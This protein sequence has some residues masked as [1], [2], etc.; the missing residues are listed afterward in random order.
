MKRTPSFYQQEICPIVQEETGKRDFLMSFPDY[1]CNLISSVE[2]LENIADR[3]YQPLI[4]LPCQI[5]S[6]TTSGG[7]HL[8]AFNTVTWIHL[9]CSADMANTQTVKALVPITEYRLQHSL[10]AKDWKHLNIYYL[11]TGHPC[12]KTAIKKK[13]RWRKHLI[14]TIWNNF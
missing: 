1:K 6:I 9:L 4:I 7:F 14:G 13:K 11:G 3:Q 8:C 5:T 12:N 2:T 10:T